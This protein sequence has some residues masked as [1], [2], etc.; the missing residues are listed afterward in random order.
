M[1]SYPAGCFEHAHMKKVIVYYRDQ[2]PIKNH[3][4]ENCGT[5][6]PATLTRYMCDDRTT[7]N[8][9]ET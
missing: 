9:V 5:D 8:Q 4:I 6:I 7:M 3:V 2:D 1:P